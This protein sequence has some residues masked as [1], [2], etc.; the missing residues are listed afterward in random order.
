MATTMTINSGKMQ[1]NVKSGKAFRDAMAKWHNADFELADAIAS[2]SDRVAGL[3]KIIETDKDLLSKD[4]S[5]RIGGRTDDDLTAE[6]ADMQSKID[7]ENSAIAEL[8]SA[9][10]DRYESARKY[11]TKDIYT[12]YKAYI[13]D[14]NRD[15]YFGALCELFSNAGF[16][17]THDGIDAFIAAVG[18]KKNSAKNK[19]RTGK[20][21]GAFAYTTWRD[22]FLGE[23]CD[24]MG[25]ALPLYKFQY[26]LKQNR[27]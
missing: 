23:I 9:Q 12:A 21:N 13:M 7:A 6:I 10:A 5:A 4:Q 3:R 11:A 22:I 18:K 24:V 26:V 20:H 14:G 8:R 2:K 1:F 27:K 15:A 19:V 25:D 17:P 16:E